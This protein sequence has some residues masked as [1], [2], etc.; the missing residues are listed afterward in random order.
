MGR[1]VGSYATRLRNNYV[2]YINAQKAYIRKNFEDMD[3]ENADAREEFE[4]IVESMERNCDAL[5]NKISSYSF[6]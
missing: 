2:K 6:E 5:V 4:S 1:V 3:F